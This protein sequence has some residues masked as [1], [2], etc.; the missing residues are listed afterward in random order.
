MSPL[1]VAI[2]NEIRKFYKD[3]TAVL[4][5][6]ELNH[7]IFHHP[8]GLRL[9]LNGF[10]QLKRIFTVYSFEMPDNIKSKYQRNLAKLEF[11]YFFTQRRLILFS[12][13]DAMVVK[14]AGGVE[15]FLE[16]IG[17]S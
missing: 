12:E 9:T 8:D 17:D 13:M 16:N 3:D 7:L 5:D 15:Q 1:K 6:L 14:L 4:S 10:V 11:P 2:F